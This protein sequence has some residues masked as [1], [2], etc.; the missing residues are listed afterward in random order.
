M[1]KIFCILV[2]MSIL[3]LMGCIS[4]SGA[5]DEA[6][7]LLDEKTQQLKDNQTETEKNKQ[8]LA[9]MTENTKELKKEVENLIKRNNQLQLEID[10]LGKQ[11]TEMMKIPHISDSINVF[12]VSTLKFFI[13]FGKTI[14]WKWITA[15]LLFAVFIAIGTEALGLWLISVS[16]MLLSLIPLVIVFL[17]SLFVKHADYYCAGALAILSWIA[18]HEGWSIFIGWFKLHK[19]A[20][21]I[22]G[23]V[24][25]PELMAIVSKFGESRKKIECKPVIKPA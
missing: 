4:T 9:T 1:K 17:L 13:D 7:K 11:M 16:H 21:K 22:V 8:A 19:P 2:L 24:L 20:I 5:L 3:T 18:S 14:A 12:L 15:I 23:K 25:S 6:R 10:E